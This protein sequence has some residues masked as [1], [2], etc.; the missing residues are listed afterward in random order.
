L[1]RF[2]EPALVSRE[3]RQEV[4]PISLIVCGTHDRRGWDRVMMGSVAE[5]IVRLAPCPVLTVR[6][7]EGAVAA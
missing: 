3:Q 6:A 5:R 1:E 7:V 4:K 2:R